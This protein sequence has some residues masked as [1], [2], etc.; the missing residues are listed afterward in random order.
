MDNKLCVQ[1]A[2]ER[3]PLCKWLRAIF[4]FKNIDF[5]KKADAETLEKYGW[6]LP[7]C[8]KLKKACHAQ[9]SAYERRIKS[10]SRLQ[11]RRPSVG[12]QSAP[13]IMSCVVHKD[14]L[15]FITP[16]QHSSFCFFL[17]G[18]A[19]KKEFTDEIYS[20]NLNGIGAF[21]QRFRTLHNKGNNKEAAERQTE[22]VKTFIS[23]FSIPNFPFT[24]STNHLGA[25]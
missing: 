4:V 13:K 1:P 23:D 19:L 12:P 18:D 24:P 22:R 7:T 3:L 15:T 21:F 20:Q 6:N 11:Q 16:L 17:F 2:G 9:R 5:F 8:H 14:T 25:L 10:H